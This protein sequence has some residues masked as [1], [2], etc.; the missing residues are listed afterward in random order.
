MISYLAVDAD[1]RD[2]NW[3]LGKIFSTKTHF[4]CI[5][6]WLVGTAISKCHIHG[7]PSETRTLACMKRTTKRMIGFSIWAF[8]GTPFL[9]PRA[10]PKKQFSSAPKTW[11]ILSNYDNMTWHLNFWTSFTPPTCHC[12]A[13]VAVIGGKPFLKYLSWK[14]PAVFQRKL[15]MQLVNEIFKLTSRQST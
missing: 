12:S 13:S 15:K 9:K 6:H 1:R 4:F 7:P 11:W 3:S 8:L 2:T 14:C 5:W 10:F